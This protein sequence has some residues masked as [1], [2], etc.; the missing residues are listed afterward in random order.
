MRCI[1]YAIIIVAMAVACVAEEQE[2]RIRGYHDGTLSF[3]QVSNAA[4]YRISWA[5][6]ARGPWSLSWDGFQ[7]ITPA[8]NEE[9]T[10][11]MPKFYRVYAMMKGSLLGLIAHYSF[12]TPS[13][14][15]T[16]LDRAVSGNYAELYGPTWVEADAMGGAH[17][18]DGVN[19]YIEL[20]RSDLYQTQGQLSGCVWVYRQS[21]HMIF[22]SNYLGGSAYNGQ[23]SF[24]IDGQGLLYASFG[25]GPRQ[26]LCYAATERDIMPSNEWHHVAFTYNEERGNGQKI[27]L[28]LDGVERTNY[29]VIAEG[30]GAPILQT[31]DRLRMMMNPA[32]PFPNWPCKGMIH[33]IMLFD[34][35]LSAAEVKQIYDMQ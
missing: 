7:R 28:Y 6:S 10:V 8:T 29:L 13:T 16:I 24:L 18:F 2:L 33:E 34:R 4:Y 25:Q 22:L 5:P 17:D 32:L 20:G 11:S 23:F 1:K 26:W 27:K 30:N 15:G 14:T 12:E 35:T 9:M 31:S 3:N 21:R 19:D